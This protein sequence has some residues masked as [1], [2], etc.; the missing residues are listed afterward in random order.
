MLAHHYPE[1]PNL[2]DFT[3]IQPGDAGPIDLLVGGT[4]CQAFSVAGKRLGLDDPR[5]NLTLEWLALVQ[6]LRPRWVAWENVPGVL[7]DDGGRTFGTII[8]MLGKLGYRYA[9]RVLDAQ[10][11]GLAQRR[12]RVFLVGSL[13]NGPHPGAVLLEP[14]SMLGVP[15]ENPAPRHDIAYT[16]TACTGPRS[17]PR[18]RGDN[19]VATP[20]PRHLMPLECERA[21][22]FQDGY[23]DIT[24]QGKKALDRPRYKALGNSM[25]VPVM[26]WIGERIAFVD[27]LSEA[28]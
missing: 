14:E 12:K 6:R 10:Y 9:W 23:T 28:A 17:G 4:P 27:S 13:G 24:Y 20:R 3:K 1:V 19:I 15:C 25:A 21:Q 11:F 16:I 2:G 22:G 5:G 18:G 7:S 26:R 8:G